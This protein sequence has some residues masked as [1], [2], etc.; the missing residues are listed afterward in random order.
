MERLTRNQHVLFRLGELIAYSEC[1]GSLSR[2]AAGRAGGELNPKAD[3]RFG[4]PALA[5]LARIFARE[6]ALKVAR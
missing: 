3:T 4:A 1:A 5:A 2:R 6:A